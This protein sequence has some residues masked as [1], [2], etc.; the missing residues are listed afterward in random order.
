MNP[1]L[2][3]DCRNALL[4]QETIEELTK[5]GQDEEAIVN[6]SRSDE[7]QELVKILNRSS[8]PPLPLLVSLRSACGNNHRPN[9]RG[10]H[11]VIPARG[12]LKCF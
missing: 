8:P 3:L 5:K 10:G 1:E 4:P 2:V 6:R 12:L 9:T 7:C 11:W